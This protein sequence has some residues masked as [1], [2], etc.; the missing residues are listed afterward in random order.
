MLAPTTPRRLRRLGGMGTG[1]NRPRTPS[2]GLV[3]VAID[4][5]ELLGA[6]GHD[7]AA[8]LPFAVRAFDPATEPTELLRAVQAAIDSANR[9]ALLRIPSDPTWCTEGDLAGVAVRAE[10]AKGL[11]SEAEVREW[12]ADFARVLG[13]G[14]LDA[15]VAPE[16]VD[17][18]V[19]NLDDWIKMPPAVTAFFRFT[20][21]MD[22]RLRRVPERVITQ[23]A[24]Q[25][26]AW[27]TLPNATTVIERGLTSFV[28]NN[29]AA[30]TEMRRSAALD[31]QHG[32]AQILT[33]QRQARIIRFT[34][35]ARAS[36][37]VVDPNRTPAETLADLLAPMRILA[38]HLDYGW[39]RRAMSAL[40]DE[41]DLA[42]V[43]G[44]PTSVTEEAAMSHPHLLGVYVIDAHVA[45]VL[46][47]AHLARAGTLD[48]YVLEEIAQD[49]FLAVA[50]DPEPWLAER[51]P[52]PE[53]LQ[54][55]RIEFGAA[56][57]TTEVLAANPRRARRRPT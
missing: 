28:V 8:P 45:Q 51:K 43:L 18:R 57:L 36:A 39:V 4:V 37:Q 47:S 9:A 48:S 13:V 30:A 11:F 55:A 20:A 49:R 14:P 34:T 35:R 42:F 25:L 17:A 54:R 22:G 7:E 29:R 38:T 52:E 23:T 3:S 27:S 41:Q 2:V 24:D 33:S 10:L 26:V 16:V 31:P 32:V 56:L 21:E 19:P 12:F 6:L 50:R 1:R 15:L 46:T 53:V 44:R 5:E 40:P